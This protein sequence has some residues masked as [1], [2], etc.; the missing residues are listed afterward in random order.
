ML[1][2]LI[3]AH[4]NLDQL[5]LLIKK[6]KT[7]NSEIYVHLDKK[8]KKYSRIEY[9]HYIRDRQDIARWWFSMIK[10]ELTWIKEIYKNMNQWDHIVIIS[11]QCLPIKPINHIETYIE[12]LWNK[13]CVYYDDI[14]NKNKRKIDRY[15]F[16]DL[17]FHMPKWVDECIYSI[18][19]IFYK[20]L[21]TPHR[22][23]AL[24]AILYVIVNLFLP[25]RKYITN[26]YTIYSWSQWM[27]LSYEHVKWILNFLE[28]KKWK[29]I[30]SC[31]N[32]TS[33]SDEIFFQT[34]LLNNNKRDEI[35]NILLR[36][37]I[38]WVNANSPTTLTINN[39]KDI[40]KSD[41]LFARKFDINVDKNIIK[42]FLKL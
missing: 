42:S 6:L 29:K 24:N 3:L 15:H 12:K 23:P 14:P 1:Y 41:K 21:W 33:C 11:W 17:K 5:E 35:N 8:I 28:S 38:R 27:V 20:K 32:Y 40:K 7:N 34:I 30:L 39:L 13:S 2:Y 9:V 37:I 10:A 31:F 18:V 26:M 19:E 16:L 22:V 4:N 36:Y 25:R